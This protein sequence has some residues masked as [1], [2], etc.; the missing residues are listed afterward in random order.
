MPGYTN[1]DLQLPE[2]L[3]GAYGL[4]ENLQTLRQLRIF[5][6]AI[7]VL[8][9]MTGYREAIAAF[10]KFVFNVVKDPRKAY[11]RSSPSLSR[12]GSTS[13]RSTKK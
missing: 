2:W 7:I 13:T 10:I 5:L 9:I 8:S 4:T 11:Q 12:I 3:D 6:E 1:V